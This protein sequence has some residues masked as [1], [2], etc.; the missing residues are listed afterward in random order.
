MP[1]APRSPVWGG[2]L[3]PALRTAAGVLGV[4][5]GAAAL[6]MLL[7][8]GSDLRIPARLWLIAHGSGIVLGEARIGVVP[9][10][11]TLVIVALT[12]AVA[13]RVARADITDVG[14][15]AGTVGMI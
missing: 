8:G 13:H 10:G 1:D 11:A 9:L 14:G 15:F 5:W 12:A 2:F 4:G 6:A 3:K 7:S